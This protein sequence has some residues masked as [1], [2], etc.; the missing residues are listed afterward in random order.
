MRNADGITRDV[1]LEANSPEAAMVG[2]PYG[3]HG[4]TF[5]VT[6]LQMFL[7]YVPPAGGDAVVRVLA[8]DDAVL[9]VR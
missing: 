2:K 6:R 4:R 3:A 7:S 9:A 1:T 5:T 8:Y